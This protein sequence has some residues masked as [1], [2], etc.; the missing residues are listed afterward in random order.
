M[1][2][3]RDRITGVEILK[4]SN[5]NYVV[6]LFMFHGVW[7]LLQDRNKGYPGGFSPELVDGT[8][9]PD[10]CAQFPTAAKAEE[11]WEHYKKNRLEF[12][13]TVKKL[14]I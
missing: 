14:A 4:M 8:Y 3:K 9:D 7:Q 13:E 2:E 10:Y 12:S 6:K 5:G 1:T 11:C